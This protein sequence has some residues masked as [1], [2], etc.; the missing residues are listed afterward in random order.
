MYGDMSN[1]MQVIYFEQR[2]K[3]QL[4]SL[5]RKYKRLHNLRA[6]E[7]NEADKLLLR[8]CQRQ[9]FEVVKERD[10]VTEFQDLL[11]KYSGYNLR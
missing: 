4:I 2:R 11:V 5:A 8:Q 1:K 10:Q 3:A 9:I 7:E 6:K